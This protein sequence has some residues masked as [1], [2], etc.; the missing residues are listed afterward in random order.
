MKLVAGLLLSIF[1]NY[2]LQAPPKPHP[3][4]FVDITS[5]S[6][7]TWNLQNL[8]PGEDYLIETMGGGGGFLDY[9]NDGWLDIY[10]VCYS[11]T[12]QPPSAAKLSDVLYETMVMA[13]SLT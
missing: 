12:P 1:P 2:F 4:Q 8:A 11:Q 10:L 6:G 7:I 5:R 9:N 13:H 3:I